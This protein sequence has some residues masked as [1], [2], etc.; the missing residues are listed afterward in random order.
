MCRV[1]VETYLYLYDFSATRPMSLAL[2]APRCLSERARLAIGVVPLELAFS[3]ESN[4]R[5]PKPRSQERVGAA[6]FRCAFQAVGLL[7]FTQPNWVIG[8]G[9]TLLSLS[10]LQSDARP[11]R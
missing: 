2:S 8:I 9:S 7:V 6:V 4:S 11:W 5:I 10:N 3:L 1:A